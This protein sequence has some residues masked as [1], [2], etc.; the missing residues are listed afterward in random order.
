M[1]PSAMQSGPARVLPP[2]TRSS[3]EHPAPPGGRLFEE[4]RS[5]HVPFNGPEPASGRETRL[6][7]LV[8][9]VSL[10]VLLLLARFQFPAASIATVNPSPGPL[11]GMAA[12]ATFEEMAATL[13][14]V[15]SRA[16]S[17]VDVIRLEPPPA[18][19]D[20]ERPMPADAG[21]PGTRR[22]PAP[23]SAPATAK[24]TPPPIPAE[25]FQYA[26][27]LRVR[28]DLALL[29]VPAGWRPTGLGD[30][31]EPIEV[32]WSDADREIALVR[33][34]PVPGALP[35]LPPSAANVT[36]FLYVGIV[37]G[38]RSGA[39]IQP[40]FIGRADTE[41][42]ARWAAPLVVLSG[43]PSLPVGSLIYTIDGRLVGL[44]T[45]H[46]AGVAIIPAAA[47]EDAV[48]RVP[49]AGAPSE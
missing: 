29:R 2:T 20:V 39:T 41:T 18:A 44:T 28:P 22:E 5:F 14:G 4:A 31:G 36:G 10:A 12:R 33:L 27:A 47:L 19:A 25:P 26:A 9:V 24:G 30:R 48:A 3:T 16:N 6:L 45:R 46:D 8:V 40:A 42:D 15:L 49:N 23:A 11:A 43:S 17:T 21:A 35:G 1:P 32:V 13:A 34:P 38:T 37:Q 7:V